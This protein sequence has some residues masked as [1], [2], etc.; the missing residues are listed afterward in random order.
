MG[1]SLS[2]GKGL[3]L[4]GASP[5]ETMLSSLQTNNLS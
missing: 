3:N 4:Y 5:Y 2:K 1:T